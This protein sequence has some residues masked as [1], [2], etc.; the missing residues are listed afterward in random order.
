[1]LIFH[2]RWLKAEREQVTGRANIKGPV[3]LHTGVWW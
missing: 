3:L 2:N 1:M